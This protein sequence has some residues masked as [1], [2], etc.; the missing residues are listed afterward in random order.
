MVGMNL[1]PG[2]SLLRHVTDVWCGLVVDL[3]LETWPQ[4]SDCATRCIGP[5][6]SYSRAP[7]LFSQ[8]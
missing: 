6:T 5:W 8:P 3:N 7:S 1:V 2:A 4:D